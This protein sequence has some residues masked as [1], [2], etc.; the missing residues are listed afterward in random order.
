MD[1][2]SGLPIKFESEPCG[3][4]VQA[5][6]PGRLRSEL[7]ARA[8][9]LFSATAPPALRPSPVPRYSYLFGVSAPAIRTFWGDVPPLMMGE[10]AA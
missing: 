9:P 5:F 4:L 7:M 10:A 3:L 1:N 6:L 2:V 8:A